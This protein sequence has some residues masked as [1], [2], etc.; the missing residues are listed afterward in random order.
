M[1][2]CSRMCNSELK[3]GR[4]LESREVFCG[5]SVAD[6]CGT[7]RGSES[8]LRFGAHSLLMWSVWCRLELGHE[9]LSVRFGQHDVLGRCCV[10]DVEKSSFRVFVP[11]PMV[12]RIGEKTA[13]R[14]PDGFP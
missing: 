14:R 11:I 13:S 3:S 5:R 12:G 1:L 9:V 8:E 2:I 10:A 6:A 7:A 4:C